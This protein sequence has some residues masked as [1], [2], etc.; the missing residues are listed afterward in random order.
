MK[1]LIATI[2]QLFSAFSFAQ[3]Y[4]GC[5]KPSPLPISCTSLKTNQDIERCI[6]VILVSENEIN[7]WQACA[8]EAIRK[9]QDQ[10]IDKVITAANSLRASRLHFIQT[11][12][13][14]K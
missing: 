4:A 12:R 11:D 3:G 5:V 2:V 14:I 7:D 8:I 10:Q 6:D 9:D 13:R 1:Y